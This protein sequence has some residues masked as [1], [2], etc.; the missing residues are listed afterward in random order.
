MHQYRQR[1]IIYTMTLI[2]FV[3]AAA[4][5]ALGVFMYRNEMQELEKTMSLV[6]VPWDEPNDNFMPI[7]VLSPFLYSDVTD[8]LQRDTNSRRLSSEGIVTVFVNAQTG[9]ILILNNGFSINPDDII[10][11]VEQ[12]I[13][14]KKD[15]GSLRSSGYIYRRENVGNNYKIALADKAYIISRMARNALLLFAVFA[16]SVMLFFLISLWLSKLAVKPLERAAALERQFVADISHDLKTPVTIVLAN[17]S[18][19]RSNPEAKVGDQLQ[20]I[21][22]TDIAAKNMISLVDGMLTLSALEEQKRIERR[23]VNLTQIAKKCV[24]QMESIAYDRRIEFKSELDDGVSALAEPAYAEKILG[25]LI[26][27]A[28]KYEPEGGLVEIRLAAVRRKA[29]FSVK[30]NGSFIPPEDIEHIFERFYRG[31]KARTK[32]GHGLG[33]PILKRTA[34]LIGAEIEAA[35]N[36]TSGTVFTAIFDSSDN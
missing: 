17:N 23:S 30:N 22:S 14:A 18:I 35:S 8:E 4:F 34:E 31:D 10:E 5:F 7:D 32:S 26:E 33:L 2:V 36:E 27:N 13:S 25:G 15:F 16:L 3:L 9:V 24:L 20:W 29:R 11:A 19:L 12:I 1:F 21:N 28:L 6:G